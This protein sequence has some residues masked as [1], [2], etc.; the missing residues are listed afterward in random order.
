MKSSKFHSLSWLLIL[1]LAM[2]VAVTPMTTLASAPADAVP[3][4]ISLSEALKTAQEQNSAP[5][6]IDISLESET[7]RNYYMVEM[8]AQDGSTTEVYVDA[9]TGLIIDEAAVSATEQDA[10][11]DD[12]DAGDSN[13][14][15]DE[16][17]PNN[18]QDSNVSKGDA[19]TVTVTVN[20]GAVN[21]NSG[22]Q[23]AD[24][25][26]GE[27]EFQSQNEDQ[28]VD[29]NANDAL[30]FSTIKIT[31]L[32][33]IQTAQSAVSGAQ[34]SEVSLNAENGTFVYTVNLVSGNGIKSEVPVDAI[35]GSIIA[36]SEGDV[37]HQD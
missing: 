4:L 29:E 24:G 8:L 32:Q 6:P 13:D 23:N 26:Q 21:D 20:Q 1:T 18:N 16:V 9:S 2:M 22:N 25:E 19:L 15:N 30:M 27:G 34:V 31:M 28:N 10:N 37:E 11:V 12:E 3:V 14:Q 7:G 35:T 17:G 5:I 33:A 36:L